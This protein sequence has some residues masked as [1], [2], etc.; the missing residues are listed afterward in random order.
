MVWVLKTLSGQENRG[1][2][3]FRVTFVALHIPAKVERLGAEHGL[4]TD[5]LRFS[6]IA[7]SQPSRVGR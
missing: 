4:D 3:R 2:W 7:Y 1:F 6:S 5:D